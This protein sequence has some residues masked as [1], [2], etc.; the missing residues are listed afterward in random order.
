[1]RKMRDLR[2]FFFSPKFNSYSSFVT[3]KGFMEIGF[4]L[5]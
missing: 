1:M 5:E 4:S 2:K 3:L